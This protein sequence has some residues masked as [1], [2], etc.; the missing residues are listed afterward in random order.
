M[1]VWYDRDETR[2]VPVLAG[3]RGRVVIVDVANN[4]S[5][6][7]TRSG[8]WTDSRERFSVTAADFDRDGSCD[9][10][11]MG[12]RGATIILKQDGS[13]FENFPRFL[14]RA[15]AFTDSAGNIELITEDRS[16][17]ALADLDQDGH[18]DIIFTGPNRVFAINYRGAP[19]EGWP[20]ILEE[21]QNVGFLY[22][23]HAF[24]ATVIQSTPLVAEL[25]GEPA[26]LIASPDGLIW[27]VDRKGD[28]VRSTSF[29]AKA[30]EV[31]Y[32]GILSTSRT[33]W[34][35]SAGGLNFD[36]TDV[37]YINI[38]LV[39]ADDSEELELFAQTGTGGACAWSLSLAKAGAGNTWLAPG[40]N[41]RR[42]HYLDAEQLDDPEE[43]RERSVIRD[44]HFYP[45]PLQ[46]RRVN[47]ALDIGARAEKARIRFYDLAGMVVQDKTFQRALLP[48]RQP[49]ITVDLG[50]LGPD[51]YTALMEVW[52]EDGTK[53]SKWQRLGVIR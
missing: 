12:S 11:V 32:G 40:G 17:P 50:H 35:L 3:A 5:L 20:F 45:S 13:P 21:R 46:G 9:V 22:S 43:Q 18:P 42:Q 38:S 52:F 24:P 7:I 27:A 29:D 44:F 36:T 37:P 2:L 15:T 4:R 31:R 39:N 1:G 49:E 14:D 6:E 47:V 34:P 26:V 48:G 41:M 53:K 10:L 8:G 23:S 51:V 25:D 33:D 30:E 16:S 19:L 28:P